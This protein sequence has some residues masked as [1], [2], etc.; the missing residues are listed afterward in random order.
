MEEDFKLML[1]LID[2]SFIILESMIRPKPVL[3]DMSFGQAYRYNETGIIQ[4][5]IQKLARVQSLVRAAFV[6]LSNGYCMEQAILNRAIDETN[7]DILFL[8]DAITNDNITEL[9][10]RYL[11]AF[12][13]EEID[14]SGSITE[15]KQSRPMIPR[16]KI[17]AHLVKGSNKAID[18]SLISKA[19]RSI[20][21]TYSGFVHGASP[22]I[23]DMYCGEPPQYQVKGLHGTSR[24][25]EHIEDFWNYIYRT[26]LSHLLVAKVF[27]AEKLANEL[28]SYNSQFKKKRSD[29]FLT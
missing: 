25:D 4:A 29:K 8:A 3:T 12:W 24:I 14:E 26:F 11:E 6:L 9:H 18:P 28:D 27:G 16:K 5:I 2:R 15:S 17:Q 23:M 1:E 19:S 20:S 13:Q 21:K 7:E 22:H 10:E